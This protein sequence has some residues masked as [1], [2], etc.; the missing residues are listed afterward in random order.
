MKDFCSEKYSVGKMDLGA[1]QV[2]VGLL[3]SAQVMISRFV[4]LSPESGSL[5]TVQSLLGI[6]FLPL[7]LPLPHACSLTPSLS[8]NK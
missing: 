2:S 6:L 3:I 8:Q 7:S 4:R 5:L 1:P